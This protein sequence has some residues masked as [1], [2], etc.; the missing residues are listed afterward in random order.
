MSIYCILI[1]SHFPSMSLSASLLCSHSLVLSPPCPLRLS[2][3][4]HSVIVVEWLRGWASGTK[5]LINSKHSGTEWACILAADERLSVSEQTAQQQLGPA[6]GRANS[7]DPQN[8]AIGLLVSWSQSWN[9]MQQFTCYFFLYCAVTGDQ[10]TTEWAGH[11]FRCWCVELS[12]L[13]NLVW[14]I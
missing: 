13:M 3:G 1:L 10:F 12:F 8:P 4:R 2:P 14:G 6:G 5:Q 11:I 9:K 7:L